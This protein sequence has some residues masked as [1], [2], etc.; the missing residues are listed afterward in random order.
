MAPQKSYTD[1]LQECGLTWPRPAVWT[2]P[3]DVHLTLALLLALPV[4]LILGQLFGPHLRAPAVWLAWFSLLLVQP[5]LEELVFR[6]LLQGQA[7]RLI[8]ANG[9]PRRWG[10]LTIANILVTVA[11]VALH[12]RAQPLD[13]ALAVAAPSIILG[14]LRERT[15]SVWP[16]VLVHAFYNAGFGLTA[17]LVN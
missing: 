8:S 3:P 6:G 2:W 13:W 9:Q 11:F 17:W 4:W 15:G 7:L 5:L 16:P 12:M 1:L 10:P 14:H